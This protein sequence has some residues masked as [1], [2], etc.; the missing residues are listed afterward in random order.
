[1][2]LHDAWTSGTSRVLTVATLQRLKM[3][4]LIPAP[5]GWGAVSDK[6][7]ECIEPSAD[8]N[9][10]TAVSSLWPHKA[11]RSTHLLQ[12]FGWE[13]F[14][15]HP[16]CSPDLAPSYFHLFLCVKK[17]LSGQRQRFQND[18]EAEMSATVVPIP[19]GKFLGH[20]IQQLIPRYDKYLN[21]GG[22]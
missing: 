18:R 8:R 22:E 1:M 21:S 16:L 12:E 7:F 19:G 13:V 15:H 9:S 5:A 4:A 17:F 14:N 20:R 10:S 3:D 11:R 6:V 2:T